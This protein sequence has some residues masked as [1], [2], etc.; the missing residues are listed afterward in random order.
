M[1]RNQPMKDESEDVPLPEKEGEEKVFTL[2]IGNTPYMF[3]SEEEAKSFLYLTRTKHV[4]MEEAYEHILKLR[5]EGYFSGNNESNDQSQ[6]FDPY[7]Y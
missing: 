4:V 7:G 5:K 6:Q 2:I 1:P 3:E